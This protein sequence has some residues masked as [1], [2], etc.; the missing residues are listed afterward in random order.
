MQLS[1]QNQSNNDCY[2]WMEEMN[3]RLKFY[4]TDTALHEVEASIVDYK[5][6]CLVFRRQKM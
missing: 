3:N 1:G 4:F 5:T 6:T 2:H